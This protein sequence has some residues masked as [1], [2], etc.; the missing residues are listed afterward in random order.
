MLPNWFNKWNRENPKDVFGP[1]ILVGAL[2]G[3]V[4][5]AIMI[6]AWGNPTP[7]TVCKP[8]RAA[9]VCQCRNLK[10]NWLFRIL[11]LPS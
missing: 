6:V 10:P 5:V 1:G 2:G 7:R 9:R 8:G 4:F 11:I 3:A